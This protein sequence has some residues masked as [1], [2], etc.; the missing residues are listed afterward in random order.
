MSEYKMSE[1]VA[2]L[3]WLVLALLT[4]EQG[5]KNVQMSMTTPAIPILKK[6]KNSTQLGLSI[7]PQLNRKCLLRNDDISSVMDIIGLII[8]EKKH[9]ARTHVYHSPSIPMRSLSSIEFTYRAYIYQSD[10][11]SSPADASIP[12]IGLLL[13]GDRFLCGSGFAE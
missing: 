7:R 9:H 13:P 5:D 2:G 8:G 1:S 11:L 12:S 6:T 10:T 4:Y 3:A